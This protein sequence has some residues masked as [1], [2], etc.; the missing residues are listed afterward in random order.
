MTAERRAELAELAER[1]GFVLAPT[2]PAQT[3]PPDAVD[4][5]LFSQA[6]THRSYLNEHG[7]PESWSN[8]R[9]EFLGDAV[10]GAVVTDYLFHHHPELA[11]GR[12][13]KIK[14]V[15]VSRRLLAR[16][17]RQMELGR[18]LLLGRG[19]DQTGGRIRPSILANLFE[20]LLGAIYLSLGFDRARELVLRLLLPEILH[21]ASGELVVDHKSILQELAQR[22]CGTVPRYRVVRTEGPDHDKLFEVEVRL[23]ERMI[24]A[25]SGKSKKTAEQKAAAA[26][27]GALKE[28]PALL[29][30][31]TTVPEAEA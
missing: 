15:V 14:S 1:L 4:L 25:G 5:D 18:Y 12:L 29:S 21:V 24:G 2:S 30:G 27:L 28:N 17:A 20:A 26:A 10:L 31:P 9:L 7:M 23:R 19:E 13:S 3:P 22:S 8:E 6:F 16:V 11:E